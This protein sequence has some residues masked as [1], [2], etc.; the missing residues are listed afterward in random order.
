MQHLGFNVQSHSFTLPDKE[1]R[2]Q[3]CKSAQEIKALACYNGC[4]PPANLFSRKGTISNARLWKNPKT[5][6]INLPTVS[7]RSSD[8]SGY[9]RG[10]AVPFRRRK[11]RRETRLQRQG[12]ALCCRKST[13]ALSF[14]A[15]PA[16]CEPLKAMTTSTKRLL[17]CGTAAAATAPLAVTKSSVC[18]TGR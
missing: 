4:R 5:A 2:V 3:F 18:L 13:T 12:D 17:G 8:R 6:P 11:V 9:E 1:A 7:Q 15:A 14:L 10:Y 16:H